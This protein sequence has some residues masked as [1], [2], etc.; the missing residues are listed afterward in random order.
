ME[1]NNFYEKF[2]L[3]HVEVEDN[4]PFR[5][6]KTVLN[7]LVK[8]LSAKSIITYLQELDLNSNSS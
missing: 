4:R 5:G 3:S 2:P 6:A 1:L 8:A 7:E